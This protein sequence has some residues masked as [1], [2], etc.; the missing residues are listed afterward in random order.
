MPKHVPHTDTLIMKARHFSSI[1]VNNTTAKVV[2][3]VNTHACTH[4]HTHN[5]V[6]KQTCCVTTITL[7][8]E[9]AT[10]MISGSTLATTRCV[11]PEPPIGIHSAPVRKENSDIIHKLM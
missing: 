8:F 5:M 3:E 10:G 4:L 6:S 11:S 2:T 9:V 1:M 7:E